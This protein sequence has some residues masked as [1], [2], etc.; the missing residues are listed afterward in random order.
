MTRID[1]AIVADHGLS[2]DEYAAIT[3]HLVFSTLHTNDAPGAVTRLLDMGLEPFLITSTVSGILAQRLVRQLCE[4]CKVPHEAKPEELAALGV[5]ASANQNQILRAVGCDVC[6]G[7]GYRGRVGLYELL[8]LSD[9]IRPMILERASVSDIR[10][11][12]R[13][14]GMRTLRENGA[15]KVLEGLTTIEEVLRETQDYG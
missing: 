11:K 7:I 1:P 14:D 3:G 4:S 13:A 12:A 2:A 9:A 8:V 10:E 6:Q 15:A 5:E